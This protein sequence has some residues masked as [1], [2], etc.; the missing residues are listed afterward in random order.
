MVLTRRA[1]PDRSR[2]TDPTDRPD[3]GGSVEAAVVAGSEP[4]RAGDR[5]ERMVAVSGGPGAVGLPEGITACLF[6]MDG[7]IT[8]TAR[9]HSAA[10]QE[11]FD[12]F[13]KAR[14]QQ[15]GKPFL[16]FDREADYD[17]YV[18]GRDREDGTRTFLRSRG[19]ELPAG[20]AGDTAKD[21]TIAGLAQTK[22]D[23]FL[24]RV[25]QDGVEAFPGS[26][27]YLH[28]VARAGLHRA[29]VSSSA[30]CAQVLAAA[31]IHDQFEARVDGVVVADE[32]L[33][34]KPAPDSYLAAAQKLGV[35][36]GQAA[37]FE[38]ALSGVEAGRA[39]H[40]GRVVGVDRVGQADA[41][42]AHGADQVVDDLAQL[43]NPS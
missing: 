20:S 30:N 36:P 14:A 13:L 25:E 9:V 23:I 22:N 17:A 16:P 39:G 35:Q 31:G 42:R 15:S 10:W 3:R 26:V 2:P 41:L 12:G 28:A 4:V 43:L 18:D 40:F 29:V 32:H 7:V 5:A 24:R 33:A 34:G 6:D 19:I 38:D 27:R 37:V 8:D 21:E 1:Q 11:M